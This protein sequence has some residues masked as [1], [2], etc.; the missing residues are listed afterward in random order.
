MRKYRAQHRDKINEYSRKYCARHREEK[1]E[2]SR[3]DY[4]KNKERA[5][6]WQRRYDIR[7][8]EEISEKKCEYYK[9]C[10]KEIRSRQRKYRLGHP[11]SV[12]RCNAR[13]KHFGFIPLNSF[14]TGAEGHHVNYNYV[15][16]IP[17][18]LHRS[19]W[20]SITSGKGMKK[21]NKKA[22]KFLR[23]HKEGVN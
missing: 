9:Q 7:H 5:K 1:R 23:E 14:F 3:K 16:Y 17:K 8:K 22:F 13:R 10:K 19:V 2:K 4:D 21:I 15:I 18:K 6:E 11:E 20:H 12:K